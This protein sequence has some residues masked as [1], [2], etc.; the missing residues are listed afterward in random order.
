MGT[1]SRSSRLRDGL[2]NEG[3]SV[4]VDPEDDESGEGSARFESRL[5]KVRQASISSRLRAR[6]IN[7]GGSVNADS[8]DDE[9]GNFTARLDSRLSK[10]RQASIS[11]TSP[12]S[13]SLSDL[14]SDNRAKELGSIDFLRTPEGG[15]GISPR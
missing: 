14:V 8:E 1:R 5:S 2:F 12:V 13:D 11:S 3:G 6:L 15:L 9:S 10:V 7:E 4:N